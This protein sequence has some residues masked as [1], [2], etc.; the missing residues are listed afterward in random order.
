MKYGL[1]GLFQ[2]TERTARKILCRGAFLAL[3]YARF[4]G[5]NFAILKE[6][7]PSCGVWQV[8]D[9]TFSKTL[10]K[11]DGIFARML[12][13]NNFFVCTEKESVL[14]KFLTRFSCDYE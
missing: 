9:G 13:E 4:Y 3:Q 11:G 7:S 10:I 6:K 8:Y 2:K 5:A 1:I 12:R 14:E